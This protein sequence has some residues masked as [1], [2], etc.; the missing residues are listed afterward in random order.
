VDWKK[1]CTTDCKLLYKNYEHQI[2]FEKFKSIYNNELDKTNS[3]V[4]K[5]LDEF[6]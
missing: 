5:R 1:A 6:K 3:P 4:Q 2:S